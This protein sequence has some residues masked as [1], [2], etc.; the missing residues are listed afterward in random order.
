MGMSDKYVREIGGNGGWELN[1]WICMIGVV[2]TKARG[3]TYC[4]QDAHESIGAFAYLQMKMA[5]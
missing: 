3:E 4:Y 1:N 5:A 2:G